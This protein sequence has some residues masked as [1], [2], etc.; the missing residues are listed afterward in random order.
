MIPAQADPATGLLTV[1][2]RHFRRVTAYLAMI[3]SVPLADIR[4]TDDGKE[5]P[6][7]LAALAEWRF[8]GMSNKDFG[9]LALETKLRTGSIFGDPKG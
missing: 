5:I 2:L 9:C 1:D 7:T 3:E 4:W 6:V 8:T